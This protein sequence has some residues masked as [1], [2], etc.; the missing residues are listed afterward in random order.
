[1]D[2]ALQI[3]R[4]SLLPSA[5]LL[6]DPTSSDRITT[7][8]RSLLI[9][10]SGVADAQTLVAGA[11]AG[12]AVY[13]LRAGTDAVE[14][15]TALL[16]GEQN[17]ASL[18]IV[19][20][21][22]SG[23]LNLGAGWLDL[24]SMPSYL[25]QLKSWGQALTAEADILLYGCDVGQGESGKAFVNLLA[26]VTGADVAASDD[27]TG[28]AALGGDW[29][30]EVRS[31]LIE[32]AGLV[33]DNY[34]GV[35]PSAP[36]ITLPGSG[37]PELVRDI[38]LGAPT[39]SPGNFVSG[40]DLYFTA[41]DGTTGLELWKSYG[42]TA[43]TAL[44]QDIFTGTNGASP[45]SLIN[46]NGTL[47]F[48][49]ADATN[50]AELWKSNGLAGGTSLV[51]DINPGVAPSGLNN[52]TSVFSIFYFT[53][54]DGTN[55][56]ELWKSD[57][58]TAGTVLVKDIR[59]G[60]LGSAPKNLTNVN[61]TLYFTANNGLTGEE[62]W[63]SNG[64]SAGTV[65]VKDLWT[66]TYVDPIQG[67]V[68]YSSSPSNLINVNGTLYFRGG[69]PT[70][71]YELWK[72]DGTTAGTVLV[73]DIN[74]GVAGASPRYLTN[75]NGMLYFAADDGINGAELWKSDGT[76]AGT[77]LVKDISTGTS[78]A[79]LGA[80]L[81]NSFTNFNG[82]LFFTAY[83]SANGGELWKSDGTNAGTVLVKDINP[84]TGNSDIYNKLVEVNGNLYF[85][86][87]DGT[88]GAELWK[89]DGSNAGT[90]LVQ[91][92]FPGV[93]PNPVS[94]GT[95]VNSSTPANL[96]NANGTL[97]FSANNGTLGNELWAINA[98]QSINYLENTSPIVIEINGTVSDADSPNFNTG[99]LTVGINLGG[100]AVDRL[101]IRNEGTGSNQINVS[102]SNI[103]YGATQIGT[104]TG[105]IGT[106]NLVITFNAAA[107]PAIAQALV[108]NITYSN[109][110][111]DP[112]P[113]QRRVNFGLTDGSGGTSVVATKMINVLPNVNLV[114]Q[115]DLLLQNS[116]SGAARIFGL[117]R[118]EIAVSEFAQ[119]ANGT[120]VAP[121]AD[122]KI[123]SGKSDFNG[124]GI[125]DF[126]WFNTATR[127]SAIWYMQNGSTGLS[128]IISS[129]S[130]F[131]YL[132]GAPTPLNSSGKIA[133]PEPRQFGN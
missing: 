112:N 21:G 10:D 129:N 111:Q 117:N 116:A 23:G 66:G 19:S 120:I 118:N 110:S 92:L 97:Y 94:G 69:D 41:N 40:G 32:A 55:G 46:V 11:A 98:I 90:V 128:N 106:T 83:T 45:Y 74:P 49:A 15:I 78:G 73:K 8:S 48:G 67:T 51:K 109:T 80:D 79:L 20:H 50:G 130:S 121:G 132:P 27:L 4:T 13:Q 93:S 87:N 114:P 115:A 126:V 22:R 1:M 64:T 33:V 72:S 76:A 53:A 91:D 61:G 35:L 89:T 84:G 43:G 124:D 47:Y 133:L 101:G 88:T 127:E 95:T 26:Q 85:S 57:G 5:T 9:I 100:I 3:D 105:G 58:T 37:L 7:Q 54:T 36:V 44:V 102:G 14:Q 2:F 38:N 56:E 42:P 125:R 16:A 34:S 63:K 12:T 123:V 86:A 28:S 59:T 77:V 122:W 131:V 70:N 75:I 108:R 24:Q 29:D 31:G 62:L 81:P 99:T 113:T 60:P 18:Q 68:P 65:L 103:F 17:V 30:L 6:S 82:T 52:L 104:F 96:T 39:S 107:T 119:L 25:G 71:G